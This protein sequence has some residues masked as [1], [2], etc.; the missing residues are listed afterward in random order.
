M[1][2]TTRGFLLNKVVQFRRINI[3]RDRKTER[4]IVLEL[5][6]FQSVI[7]NEDRSSKIRKKKTIERR[8]RFFCDVKNMGFKKTTFQ[9]KKLL[10]LIN[11][12]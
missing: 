5:T 3:T 10:G 11:K 4:Q 1:K 2:N 6:S 9:N 8:R 12:L 7:E